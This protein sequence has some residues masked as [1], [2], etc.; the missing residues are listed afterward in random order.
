MAPDMRTGTCLLCA[1]FPL[2]SARFALGFGQHLCTE[3]QQRRQRQPFPPIAVF[4]QI[5]C[6]EDQ[7]TP[8]VESA[9]SSVALCRQD[10]RAATT[11]LTKS[12]GPVALFVR[13]PRLSLCRQKYKNNANGHAQRLLSSLLPTPVLR[14]SITPPPPELWSVPEPFRDEGP[15]ER[16]NIPKG[17]METN[18]KTSSSKPESRDTAGACNPRPGAPARPPRPTSLGRM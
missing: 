15:P 2:K 12:P 9:C 4:P 7:E 13:Q 17:L 1:C 11:A 5:L 10:P 8:S 14:E 3:T 6:L 16:E 18:K